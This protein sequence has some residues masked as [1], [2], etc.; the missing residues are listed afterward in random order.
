MILTCPNCYSQFKVSLAVIGNQPRNVRCS[1]CGEVW[2]EISHIEEGVEKDVDNNEG[3]TEEGVEGD[4]SE[5][6]VITAHEEVDIPD[7]IKPE[8]G[9]GEDEIKVKADDK[10]KKIAYGIAACLFL[11]VFIYLMLSSTSMMRAHP[12]MQAFYSLVGVHMD[13]PSSDKITF[14]NV[15]AHDLDNE[16]KVSGE[17][18]NLTGEPQTLRMMEITV[19]DGAEQVLTS[20]FAAP[21]KAVM[22]SEETVKFVSK[23]HTQG[24]TR[25]HDST[26]EH[27]DD[28]EKKSYNKD[29]AV[30]SEEPHA[31]ENRYVRV[32]FVLSPNLSLSKIDEEADGNTPVPH[33]DES[34]HQS[35]HE[36]SL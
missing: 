32:R 11:V 33:G 3:E 26:D 2:E 19:T 7:S 36:A 13:I 14:A 12:S 8:E 10:E 24:S 17:I 18:I 27:G 15:K 22:E 4:I 20:W 31:D 30:E 6:D 34:G 5:D 23:Y 35:D 16:I 28:H 9:D 1:A 25:D 21:P 29:N